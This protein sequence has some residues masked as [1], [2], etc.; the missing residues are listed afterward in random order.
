MTKL[1]D[2][3]QLISSCKRLPLTIDTE[4]LTHEVYAIPTELW[5]ETRSQ[6][7]RDV[8]AIFFKGYPP[9]Q[10][11]PD[12]EREILAELPYLKEIINHIIPG[13]TPRKCTA[14]KLKQNGYVRMHR[15]GWVDDKENDDL[16]FYDYFNSTIR[17][18]IPIVTNKEATFFCNGSFFHM[19]EGEVWAVNNTN[20]HAVINNHSTMERTHIIV[21]IEPDEELIQLVNNTPV[22]NGW[23]D[24]EAVKK[25]MQDSESPQVS[26]YSSDKLTPVN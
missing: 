12:D 21:D 10:R 11:K 6:I 19:A 9:V 16:Y 13:K 3:N 2:K 25:L 1:I 5:N 7:H 8:N 26:Q 4:K 24:A 18:H 17:I 23:K 20:D 14:V 22:A 15:D